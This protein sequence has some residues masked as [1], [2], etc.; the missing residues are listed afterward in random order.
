[1]RVSRPFGSEAEFLAAERDTLSRST[2]VLLGVSSMP[3]GT[4]LRFDLV[5]ADGKPFLRGEGRVVEFR[6]RAVR[7]EPGL[8]VRFTKLDAKSKVLVDKAHAARMAARA[9]RPD[10]DP[11]QPEPTP[12]PSSQTPIEPDE[13]RDAPPTAAAPPSDRPQTVADGTPGKPVELAPDVHE[14]AAPTVTAEVELA[15]DVH[16]AAAP[17]VTAEVATRRIVVPHFGDRDASL[18][19]LRDRVGAMPADAVASLLARG[20]ELRAAR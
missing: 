2:V 1:L 12:E 19:R 20:R 17:T 14:A 3:V 8:L 7:E 15:A 6:E 5:L 13:P 9:S 10:A 16:E 18:Q 11:T 4:L